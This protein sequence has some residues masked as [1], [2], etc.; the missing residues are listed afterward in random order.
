MQVQTTQINKSNDE[1][2]DIENELEELNATIIDE[3]ENQYLDL[4]YLKL[5]N[6]SID[7]SV[8]RP[9]EEGKTPSIYGLN[10][11][12]NAI[13]YFKD[14]NIPTLGELDLSNYPLRQP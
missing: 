5:Q 6:F 9:A 1:I 10:L 8:P 13:E 14:N 3:Y 4:N 7:I 12:L 2:A 11:K